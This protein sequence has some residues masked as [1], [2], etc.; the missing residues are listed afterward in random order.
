MEKQMPKLT[1]T[2]NPL[3]IDKETVK[4]LGITQADDV[5]PVF[6]L[7]FLRE[8]LEQI[9]HMNWRARVDVI[10]ATRL[11]ESKNEVLKNKGHQNL[12]THLN[13]VEQSL[14]AIRQ[15]NKLTDQLLEEYPELSE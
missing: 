11:T 14:G 10:H 13:E 3:A 6:K 9:K 8:Q 2:D 1:A 15:I 12:A 7:N 5:S 4:K